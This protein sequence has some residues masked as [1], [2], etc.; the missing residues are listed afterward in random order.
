MAE[1][2]TELTIAKTRMSKFRFDLGVSF[3]NISGSAFALKKYYP[4]AKKSQFYQHFTS[5]FSHKNISKQLFYLNINSE[6]F[7]RAINGAKYAHIELW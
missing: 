4:S 5:S 3:T 2:Q 1:L 7:W 6:L